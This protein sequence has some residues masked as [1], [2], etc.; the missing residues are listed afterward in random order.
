LKLVDP[1]NGEKAIK[2]LDMQYDGRQTDQRAPKIAAYL[3]EFLHL[4]R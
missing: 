3:V 1:K 2:D 4:S